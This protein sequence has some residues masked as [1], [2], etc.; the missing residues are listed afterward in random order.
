M[1]KC[2]LCLLA[3]LTVVCSMPIAALA[4]TS[5]AIDYEYAVSA[6]CVMLLRYLGNAEH[7]VIP[8]EIDGLPVTE[9]FGFAFANNP[10][11]KSIGFPDTVKIIHEWTFLNCSSLTEITLPKSLEYVGTEIFK[12][13][14]IYG[15]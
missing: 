8:A 5:D 9:I 12:V 4:E 2:F 7:V 10:T 14:T 1:K 11:V 15:R 6:E 3:V 13:V